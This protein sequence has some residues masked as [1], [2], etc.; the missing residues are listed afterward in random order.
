MKTIE[1]KG[2]GVIGV[3]IELSVIEVLAIDR[4]RQ[5]LYD[6]ITSMSGP[7]PLPIIKATNFLRNISLYQLDSSVEAAAKDL[8]DDKEALEDLKNECDLNGLEN[9]S[10]E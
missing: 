5:E 7:T 6:I 8:F 9:Q 10:P 4:L 1:N 2:F 3:K